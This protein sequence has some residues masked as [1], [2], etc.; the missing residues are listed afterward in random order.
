MP[1]PIN[2]K[3]NTGRHATQERI[4]KLLTEVENRFESESGEASVADYIRL[5]QLELVLDESDG[6]REML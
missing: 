1:D 3:K 4:H 2:N 5:L 6:P